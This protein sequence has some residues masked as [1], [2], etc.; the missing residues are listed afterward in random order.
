MSSISSG[1]IF[2]LETRSFI[3]SDYKSSGLTVTSIPLLAIVKGDLEY[4]TITALA[5]ISFSQFS[6]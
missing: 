1:L 5:I 2:V 3:T 4:P 6:S